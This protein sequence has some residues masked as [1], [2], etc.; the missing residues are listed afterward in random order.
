MQDVLELEPDQLM[1]IVTKK[2]RI[3]I[4]LAWAHVCCQPRALF[5]STLRDLLSRMDCFT[6]PMV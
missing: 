1:P 4:P 2:M 6:K 5:A 3:M